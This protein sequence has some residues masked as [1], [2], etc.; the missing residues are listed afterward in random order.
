MTGDER[1]LTDHEVRRI[2]QRATELQEGREGSLAISG[3]TV[4]DVQK[5]G[6]ELGMDAASLQ[7]AIDEVLSGAIPTN[8]TFWGGPVA[9]NLERSVPGELAEDDWHE[10]LGQLRSLFGRTGSVAEI[11][12]AREWDGTQ[13]VLDP[14]HISVRSK[15]GMTKLSVKSDLHGTA[16]LLGV[17][18]FFPLALLT[19]GLLE[20]MTLGWQETLIAFGIFC[21]AGAL[22][23]KVL[24][25]MGSR[26]ARAIEQVTRVINAIIRRSDVE[27]IREA[28]V[29]T[30][31]RLHIEP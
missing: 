5:I 9:I 25:W 17:A 15:A 19:L 29:A 6:E 24:G 27:T 30:E 12:G 20:A 11:A 2:L 21:T 13:A 16:F 7:T 22:Y 8:R 4:S 23:R 31:Q 14:I 1:R 28:A 18:G 26:R 3:P 10:V